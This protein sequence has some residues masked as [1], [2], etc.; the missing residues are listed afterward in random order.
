LSLTSMRLF[1]TL[2]KRIAMRKVLKLYQKWSRL[3]PNSS[4]NPSRNS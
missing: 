3:S 4:R 1:F 2:S